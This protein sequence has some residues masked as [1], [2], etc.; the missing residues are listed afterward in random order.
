MKKTV[1]T[2]TLGIL[3]TVLL[4]S[5][6]GCGSPS[7]V[8]RW[9]YKNMYGMTEAF[10]EFRSD[11]TCTGGSMGH[12]DENLTYSIDSD[13]TLHFADKTY[14]KTTVEEMRKMD[15]SE[16]EKYYAFDNNSAYFW[17]N[18]KEFK[19]AAQ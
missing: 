6:A 1:T 11:G 18:D 19:R 8:G 14:Q 4:L 9:E 16:T 7:L 3:L 15:S 12:G 10:I 17:S 2:L 13:G 5:L